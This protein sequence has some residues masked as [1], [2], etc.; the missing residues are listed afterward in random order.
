MLWCSG[1]VV[2]VTADCPASGDWGSDYR[3]NIWTW[4]PAH[5]GHQGDWA[6][7]SKCCSMTCTVLNKIN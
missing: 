4:D 3:E 2:C 1:N 6:A 7:Q 5:A